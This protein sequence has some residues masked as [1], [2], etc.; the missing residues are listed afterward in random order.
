[1]SGRISSSRATRT[2]IAS[3]PIGGDSGRNSW[4]TYM[5][6]SMSYNSISPT[7]KRSNSTAASHAYSG[8]PV[9]PTVIRCEAPWPV[10]LSISAG[11]LPWWPSYD[12]WRVSS[13]HK[14]FSILN[15][16]FSIVP[17][18]RLPPR[19]RRRTYGTVSF[20]P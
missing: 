1:M 20:L 3:S 15:F 5:R 4:T 12:R 18:S 14:P 17:V 6:G 2:W 10:S 13:S 7:R 16:Q 9:F 8:T 11:S 19:S